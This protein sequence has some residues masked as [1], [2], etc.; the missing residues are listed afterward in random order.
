MKEVKVMAKAP[1]SEIIC[2][3]TE[4][5]STVSQD[6]RLD[7]HSESDFGIFDEMVC[8]PSDFVCGMNCIHEDFN[9]L[10]TD[11]IFPVNED[12]ESIEPLGLAL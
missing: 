7:T 12:R 2:Y 6:Y 4:D 9:E 8:F 3:S 10:V 11:A 5:E 1:P